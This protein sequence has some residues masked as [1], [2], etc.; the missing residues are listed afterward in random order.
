MRACS[1]EL[2]VTAN[3]EPQL[4]FAACGV[5]AVQQRRHDVFRSGQLRRGHIPQRPCAANKGGCVLWRTRS[6]GTFAMGAPH[7]PRWKKAHTPQMPHTEN[8]PPPSTSAPVIAE[9]RRDLF[10]RR[11]LARDGSQNGTRRRTH[12]AGAGHAPSD[13]LTGSWGSPPRMPENM[14]PRRTRCAGWL[15]TAHL[16]AAAAAHRGS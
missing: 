3:T 13:S 11:L 9:P 6:A 12:L 8:I 2:I 1:T 10:V 4:C 15:P 5:V 14:S 16:R 7:A